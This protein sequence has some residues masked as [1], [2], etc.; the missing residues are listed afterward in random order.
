MKPSASKESLWISYTYLCDSFTTLQD[1]QKERE[2]KQNLAIRREGN[3]C[4]LKLPL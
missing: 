4:H 3:N 1:T 2:T